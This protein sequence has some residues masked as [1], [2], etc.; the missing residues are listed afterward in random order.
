MSIRVLVVDDSAFMRKM[1]TQILTSDPGIEVTATA[2]NGADA[3]KKLTSTEVDVITLDV[4][5][6]VMNGLDT[7]RELMA[8]NPKPVIML[9]S[10]T[11]RGSE[12]TF[13]ALA[14]GAVD[15]VPKPSG[16]ISLDID[17][18]AQELIA[19]VKAAAGA[20]V[21]AYKSSPQPEKT[22]TPPPPRKPVQTTVPRGIA[23]DTVVII[24]SSTGGPKALEQVI[25]SIPKDIPAGFL[26]VQHMPQPFTKSFAERL[27]GIGELAVKEAEEGDVVQNGMALL[28]P[29]SFHM[30]VDQDKR[31]RL[32][33]D[34]PVQ[35]VR[36]SID[37]TMASLP[38]VF[39]SR[40]V[41]VILTGMGRDGADGM[42]LI[43]NAGGLTI[44]QDRLTSTI[45]SMP[46]AVADEGHADYILSLDRI[47]ESIIRLVHAIQSH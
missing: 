1:I 32:N 38:E 42:G 24:G 27:N 16:E 15:F 43:K 14:L 28:A 22:V 5:M 17:T 33:Q 13:Q 2:R 40:I 11:K 9:S 36:P 8:V 37:V 23:A 19:K 34:P 29:G 25:A 20:R 31:I 7:L 39:G 26:I 41:G 4:E 10:R 21:V 44:A 46:K 18:I 12:I 45:Y 6:P 30:V 47:G 3:L 35:F